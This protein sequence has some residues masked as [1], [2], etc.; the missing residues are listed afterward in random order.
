MRMALPMYLRHGRW[1]EFKSVAEAHKGAFD[2]ALKGTVLREIDQ[3]ERIKR[4][5]RRYRK[6]SVLLL[7]FCFILLIALAAG[8][9]RQ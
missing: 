8:F 7:G 2:R 9:I 4:K 3:E 5:L 1:D 6:L